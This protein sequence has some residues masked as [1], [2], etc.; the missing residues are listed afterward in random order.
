MDVHILYT[1]IYMFL[2]YV[3]ELR[4][5]DKLP[6]LPEDYNGPCVSERRILLINSVSELFS[7]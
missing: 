3:S 5:Y 1:F 7:Q 4:D 6:S 2:P